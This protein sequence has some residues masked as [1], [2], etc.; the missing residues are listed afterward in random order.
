MSISTAPKALAT[1]HAPRTHCA[2]R[3]RQRMMIDNVAAGAHRIAV[4]LL[5][6]APLGGSTSLVRPER[7]R[8]GGRAGGRALEIGATTTDLASTRRRGTLSVGVNLSHR[9]L[10]PS[11][12]AEPFFPVVRLA[13]LSRTSE[14]ASWLA[15]RLAHSRLAP[16]VTLSDCQFVARALAAGAAIESLERSNWVR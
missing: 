9:Y 14:R 7:G 3:R 11:L 6:L 16:T 1:A 4:T 8:A 10:H 12:R 5:H 15:G 2:P 13:H